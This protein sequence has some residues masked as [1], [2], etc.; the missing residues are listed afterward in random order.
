MQHEKAA[1]SWWRFR[2]AARGQVANE[3]MEAAQK[4][5]APVASGH[6][7]PTNAVI[8]PLCEWGPVALFGLFAGALLVYPVLRPF[9][10]VEVV[11][12]EGWNVYYA[13]AADHHL[14]LNGQK[15]GWTPVNYPALR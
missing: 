10:M 8:D 4:A 12:N 5:A 15:F 9:T 7:Q 13:A 1:P 11:C 2:A 3:M 14:S 6:D